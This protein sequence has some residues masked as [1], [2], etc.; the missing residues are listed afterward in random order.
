[1]VA[2]A[3]LNGQPDMMRRYVNDD[4]FHSAFAFD[5]LLA[6]WRKSEIE[7]AITHSLDILAA[8]A[9]DGTVPIWT[10]NNHD[11]P[12]VV[13]RLGRQDAD[14]V[15]HAD[16]HVMDAGDH[17]D[18]VTTDIGLRRARALISLTMALPGSLYLY[19]GEELGLPEVL[20]IPAER[21]EDPIFERTNGERIGRD[22]CR[23]PLPWTDDRSTAFGFSS[24]PNDASAPEPWLPQ[25]EW[26]GSLAVDEVDGDDA[27]TLELYRAAAEA[28]REHAIA[29]GVHAD[30]L[31]LGPGLV[32]VARG[33]LVA[34]MNVT[35]QPLALDLDHPLLAI[36]RPVFASEPSEMHTPGVIPPDATI[37][38]VS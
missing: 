12:R 32:A 37:W 25:P 7:Q 3:Y 14:R 33:D 13:T 15:P 8:D 38:F 29:Q 27:S 9:D 30:V 6:A 22:G 34:V 26:W 20:D 28:R 16:A 2:E 10:L 21:R 17:W 24:V 18:E 35:R 31:E 5:L 4:A 11:V 23:I 19:Q 1:M 36:T